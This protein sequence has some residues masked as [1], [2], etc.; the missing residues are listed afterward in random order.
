MEH[1][2]TGKNGEDNPHRFSLMMS[3]GFMK[4]NGW[5]IF[6]LLL[7]MILSG[8]QNDMKDVTHPSL[9]RTEN[10]YAT[11]VKYTA[12]NDGAKAYVE[13]AKRSEALFCLLEKQMDAFVMDAYNYQSIDNEGT[14]LYT[15]NELTLPVEVD[16]EGHHIRV[17]P[18]YFKFNPIETV[19]GNPI[20]TQMIWDDNTL[21]LLVPEQHK[22]LE[23][24]IIS[25]YLDTF[26][27]EK[28][29]V[30]NI[31]RE[32]MGQPLLETAK[33]ELYV[34]IIYVKDGQEYFTFR[35]DLAAGMS[36]I[37]T[38]PIVSVYTGNIHVSYAHSFMSQFVYFYAD[39]VNSQAAY[40]AVLP[41]I[42]QAGAENSFQKVNSVKES[43]I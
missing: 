23:N 16:A 1:K 24:E 5:L 34:N 33:E 14:P 18:N 38:D 15:Q 37:I 13:I 22:E 41:Y 9:D 40:E 31:H 17:S 39:A 29:S 36:N 28:I 26:Y 42:Q 32:E 25:E 10:I 20:E 11:S 21:N 35:S 4:K 7:G 30:D 8:C 3:G 2:K 6:V 12:E 43:F 19:S 27:F